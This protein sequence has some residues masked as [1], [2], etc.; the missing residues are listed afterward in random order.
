[1]SF[2]LGLG[3]S[4]SNTS[5]SSSSTTTSSKQTTQNQ[6][7]TGKTTQQQQS[8]T[9][10]IDPALLALINQSAQVNANTIKGASLDALKAEA[11]REF[12]QN[13]MSQIN[14]A[15]QKYGSQDNSFVQL[16]KTQGQ[17]D[18]QTQLAALGANEADKANTNLA[19]LVTASKYGNTVTNTTAEA[20]T[21]Q[22]LLN[23]ILES[24]RSTTNTSSNS[25]TISGGFSIGI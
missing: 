24:G 4:D 8:T 21:L 1:M 16:L 11:V 3:I 18:L 17:A 9:Q 23:Q 7:Q 2:G 5:G 19:A 22:Q 13:T 12:N 25:N 15:A 14:Q 6:T 10:T 20:N